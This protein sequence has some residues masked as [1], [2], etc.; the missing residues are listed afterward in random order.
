MRSANSIRVDRVDQNDFGIQT[1]TRLN[2]SSSDKRPRDKAARHFGA[3]DAAG[4][5]GS[6]IGV[7]TNAVHIIVQRFVKRD[8]ESIVVDTC[9]VDEPNVV[10]RE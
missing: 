1:A 9:R 10:F 7:E 8:A 5:P 4:E 3:R 2:L 6:Y